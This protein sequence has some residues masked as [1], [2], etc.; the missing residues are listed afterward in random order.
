MVKNALENYNLIK[1]DPRLD[2][3]TKQIDQGMNPPSM[4]G[5]F[6]RGFLNKEDNVPA[7]SMI[8]NLLR[9]VS[10][11]RIANAVAPVGHDDAG[12]YSWATPAIVADTA[13]AMKRMLDKNSIGFSSVDDAG[14][15]YNN[16]NQ[17]ASSLDQENREAVLDPFTV[18]GAATAGSFAGV[19]FKPRNAL[20]AGGSHLEPPS[21]IAKPS[22]I[23]GTIIQ[24]SKELGSRIPALINDKG[25]ALWTPDDWN[26]YGE[27]FGVPGIGD[28]AKTQRIIDMYGNE[29]DVPET[30][31]TRNGKRPSLLDAYALKAEGIH[32]DFISGDLAQ[33][34]HENMVRATTPIGPSNPLR[35]FN[36]F[37]F[38][39]S[40]PNNPL[41]PNQIAFVQS[42]VKTPEDIVRLANMTPW[43]LDDAFSIKGG[44]KSVRAELSKKIAQDL[45]VSS[46]KTGGTGS[47]GSADWTRFSDFAKMFV[48]DPTFFNFGHNTPHTP[49]AWEQFVGKVVSQV[50]G[51]SY[52][53]G[54]FGGVWQAPDKAMISA[55]DRHMASKFRGSLFDTEAEQI[56]WEQKTV[57]NFNKKR[58]PSEWVGSIDEMLKVPG[59][60]G[61]YGEQ[62]LAVLGKH[63]KPKLMIG[64]KGEKE[65]NPNVPEHFQNNDWIRKP[66]TVSVMSPGY[67]S[68]LE[69]NAEDAA[70]RGT[71][72]FSSQWRLWDPIRQRFE[73]HEN[74]MPEIQELG[75]MSIDQILDARKA[76]AKAGFLTSPGRIR[77]TAKSN[78]GSLALF[79]NPS[80][81]VAVPLAKQI[82][83]D[84]REETL[85]EI[86]VRQLAQ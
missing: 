82:A 56:K 6:T 42:M 23:P 28:R 65:F 25:P 18:A 5:E 46:A 86:L 12:N 72:I 4:Q 63:K 80:T 7:E 85:D 35:N 36:G 13:G 67:S 68:A 44:P 52:K 33:I 55:M 11:M 19:P 3:W 20:A 77:K 70:R 53:T 83:Q 40:S 58:A 71:S 43:S 16:N 48:K 27:H 37:L 73:P 1:T 54:S 50:P 81:G 15:L 31:L 74:M 32:P 69:T 84:P 34:I 78:P 62:A 9:M 64:K 26:R 60:K 8:E 30:Y 76:H 66:E 29:Y 22:I 38:G 51:L 2:A 75:R 14:N 61:Y 10:P 41:T 39:L 79:A 59:G 24:G 47:V 45:G 17:I 57:N 21:T 49:E